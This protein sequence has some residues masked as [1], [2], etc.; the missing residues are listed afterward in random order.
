MTVVVGYRARLQGNEERWEATEPKR[1]EQSRILSKKDQG[2]ELNAQRA[3][4]DL[5]V[6]ELLL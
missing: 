6:K 1:A 2:T 5:I 4:L 3:A